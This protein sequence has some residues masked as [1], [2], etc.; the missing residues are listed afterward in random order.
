MNLACD[1]FDGI[2][3]DLQIVTRLSGYP[4]VSYHVML[5]DL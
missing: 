4:Y 2:Q 5:R 1:Y 3:F